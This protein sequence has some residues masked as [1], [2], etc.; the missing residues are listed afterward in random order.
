MRVVP[1]AISADYS[2]ARAAYLGHFA[3]TDEWVAASG[4]KKMEKSL[5]S[6]NRAVTFYVYEGTG[7]WFFEQDRAEAYNEKAAELAWQRT[8]EFLRS[9][10]AG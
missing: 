9:T 3:T 2:Q 8:I 4:V 10:L 5:R 1:D 6:A 7:H